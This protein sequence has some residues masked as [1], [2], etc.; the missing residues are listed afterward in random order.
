MIIG[1]KTFKNRTYIMGILNVT[2]DSFSDG[3]N[4]NTIN[5]ALKHTEQ[6]IKD[7]ADIIDIGGEST[8]PNY[9]QISD[10]EEI[11]RVVPIIESIKARFDIPLSI[12][13]YKPKVAKACAIAN[14]D[15]I[16]DIWGLKYNY[17]TSLQIANNA[18][19]QMANI[20][21]QYN[22]PVC[23]MHNKANASYNNY[24]LDVINELKE[25]INIALAAGITNDNIIIDPGVG[26]GKS[27][28]NNL[29]IINNLEALHSLG[30]PILLGTSR[31]SVIGLT[32]DLPPSERLEGTIVTTTM[33]VLKG[34]MFIRVHDV[35]ENKRA[36]LMSEKILG[37]W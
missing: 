2:P 8:K 36:V 11:E 12:D 32:L 35:K 30:Y 14:I 6:M 28:E 22:L 1:N 18:P 10:E 7:G 27:Y 20:I 16:N 26:F 5:K 24:I 34:A 4:F 23:I 33:G 13:T 37:R 25:S 21:A 9:T 19:N 29:E 31:K 17:Q 3:G 15:M